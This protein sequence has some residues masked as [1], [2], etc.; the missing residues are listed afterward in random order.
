MPATVVVAAILLLTVLVSVS[1]QWHE[2]ARYKMVSLEDVRSWPEFSAEVEVVEIIDTMAKG[3]PF[4][5]RQNAL[6]GPACFVLIVRCRKCRW[7]R[8]RGRSR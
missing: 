2:L 8:C 4:Y 6:S 7:S 3:R 1:C 5:F